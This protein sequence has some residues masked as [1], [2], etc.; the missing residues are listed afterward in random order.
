MTVAPPSS[1]RATTD[2]AIEPFEAPV[3]TATSPP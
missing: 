3:T 1:S 2:A